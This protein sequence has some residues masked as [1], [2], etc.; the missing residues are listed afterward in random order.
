MWYINTMD[1][2]DELM[3]LGEI[4][5][6]LKSI[7]RQ[8]EDARSSDVKILQNQQELTKRVEHLE[9]Q[10]IKSKSFVAG[11]TLVISLIG[12]AVVI[13]LSSMK[14]GILTKLFY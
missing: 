13:V 4:N 1:D 9:T 12:S 11:V 7:N 8:L 6:E 2:R 5:S 3:L 10:N 14:D